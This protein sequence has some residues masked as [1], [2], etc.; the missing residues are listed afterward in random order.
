MTCCMVTAKRSDQ[1]LGGMMKR[2][3]RRDG[4][5]MRKRNHVIPVGLKTREHGGGGA[6]GKKAD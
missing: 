2:E 3:K 4:D 5:A 6:G 1:D